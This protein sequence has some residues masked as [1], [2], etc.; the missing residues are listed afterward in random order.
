MTPKQGEDITAQYLLSVLQSTI[1]RNWITVYLQVVRRLKLEIGFEVTGAFRGPI[2]G[3]SNAVSGTKDEVTFFKDSQRQYLHYWHTKE[4][5]AACKPRNSQFSLALFHFA[6]VDDRTD[7]RLM[8]PS[9]AD[10]ELIREYRSYINQDH[11]ATVWPL[12]LEMSPYQDSVR[13]FVVQE[14]EAHSPRSIARVNQQVVRVYS[15]MKRR[16]GTRW[17]GP[18]KEVL[19]NNGYNYLATTFSYRHGFRVTVDDLRPFEFTI[20]LYRGT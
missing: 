4:N 19:E 16:A 9:Q 11:A 20:G 5:R 14:R 7:T 1:I 15:N 8:F 6:P 18:I 3:V 12:C 17:Y 2:I 13:L 10:L